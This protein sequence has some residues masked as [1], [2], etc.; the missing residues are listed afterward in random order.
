MWWTLCLL[1]LVEAPIEAWFEKV[2]K[3]SVN[4]SWTAVAR[5]VLMILISWIL[6]K[7]GDTEYWW[8]GAS[9]CFGI[10]V[11]FFNYLYNLLTRRKLLYLRSKGI[12]RVL[13]YMPPWGRW[14]LELIIF[15]ASIQIY[16]TPEVII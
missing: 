16:L 8:Q 1:P 14:I 15:G 13:A 2:K 9:L 5:G 4:H 6:W 10:F 11:A 3:I 12:D 7:V